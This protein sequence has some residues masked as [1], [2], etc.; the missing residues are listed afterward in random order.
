MNLLN[1]LFARKCSEFLCFFDI[2]SRQQEER[3]GM[4]THLLKIE[5]C[6]YES[7]MTGEKTFEIRY[8]D[9]DYQ[10]GDFIK[11]REVINSFERKGI[12][13]ITHVH[14][15]LGM[16]SCFVALAIKQVNGEVKP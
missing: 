2:K 4:K 5:D 13:M 1:L 10:K 3:E 9:R 15:G 14:S 12:W 11:F 16:E 6:Y 8:N 7:I